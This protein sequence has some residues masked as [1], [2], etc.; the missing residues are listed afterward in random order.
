ML[1]VIILIGG[2]GLL[3]IPGQLAFR[4]ETNLG[5]F[6]GLFRFADRLNLTYNL[7]PS[8]HVALSVACIA[9][10]AQRSGIVVRI[11][12]WAWA[13]AISASTVLTHQHHVLDVVTGWIVALS[14]FK[15]LRTW[16]GARGT[17]EATS[18]AMPANEA[19]VRAAR[20]PSP[21]N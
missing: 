4:P 9:T 7:V 12:L 17:E 10:Y 21:V 16:R 19:D 3:L 11:L 18:V 8:L 5:A 6:P 15:L 13:L 20:E 14:A 1:D 2:I